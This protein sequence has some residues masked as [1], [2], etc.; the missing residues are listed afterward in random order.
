M[1]EASSS[2]HEGFVVSSPV[3][4]SVWLSA[5]SESSVGLEIRSARELDAGAGGVGEDMSRMV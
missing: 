1:G 4:G 2:A 5:A 3:L